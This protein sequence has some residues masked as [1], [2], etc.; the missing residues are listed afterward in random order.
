MW[1]GQV[2]SEYYVHRIFH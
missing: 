2:K 1:S